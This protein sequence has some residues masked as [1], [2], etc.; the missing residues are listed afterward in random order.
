MPAIEGFHGTQRASEW[1]RFEF[2]RKL[3]T[4][5]VFPLPPKQIPA[6]YEAGHKN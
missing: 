1:Q 2:F 3:F 6:S 4:R 5:G